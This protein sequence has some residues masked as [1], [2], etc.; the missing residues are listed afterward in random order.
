MSDV[1]RSSSSVVQYRSPDPRRIDGRGVVSAASTRRDNQLFVGA[2]LLFADGAAREAGGND[3]TSSAGERASH[4][5]AMNASANYPPQQGVVIPPQ[6]SDAAA[7]ADL[8]P[9]R[10]TASQGTV[11]GGGAGVRSATMGPGSTRKPTTRPDPYAPASVNPGASVAQNMY[12]NRASTG[13]H[14]LPSMSLMSM[15]PADVRRGLQT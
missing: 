10:M 7:N 15:A 14:S 4:Q 11:V 9:R 2:P 12:L 5:N 3:S 13:L 6:F 1:R 8:A